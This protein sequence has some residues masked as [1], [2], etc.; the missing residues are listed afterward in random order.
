MDLHRDADLADLQQDADLAD[1]QQDADLA[2][3]V[4]LPTPVTGEQPAAW[5]SQAGPTGDHRDQ[6]AQFVGNAC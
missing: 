4:A 2:D 6:H 3:P 1:L 5:R